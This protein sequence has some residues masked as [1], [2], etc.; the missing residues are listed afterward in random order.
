MSDTQILLE[1]KNVLLDQMERTKNLI[2]VLVE[3]VEARLCDPE[4]CKVG[5]GE[6][7]TLA[8][9]LTEV[10]R[11]VEIQLKAQAMVDNVGDYR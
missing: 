10:M 8:G 3:T 1:E 2:D 7:A 9:R 5:F 11:W 4:H 6:L